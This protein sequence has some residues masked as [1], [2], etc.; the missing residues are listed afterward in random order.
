[1]TLN[2]YLQA[3]GYTYVETDGE[4]RWW[5]EGSEGENAPA[6][7]ERLDWVREQYEA[8]QRVTSAGLPVYGTAGFIPGGVA[9][10]FADYSA[11]ALQAGKTID[12]IDYARAHDA[13]DAWAPAAQEIAA[14]TGVSTIYDDELG[15]LAPV[16]FQSEV[17]QTLNPDAN[18]FFGGGPGTYILQIGAMALG[19]HLATA[20]GAATPAPMPWEPLGAVMTGAPEAVSASAWN[21]FDADDAFHSF[22]GPPLQ[23][24]YTAQTSPYVPTDAPAVFDLPAPAEAATVTSNS[25]SVNVFDADDAFHSLGGAPLPPLYASQI[26]AA[27]APVAAAV[28]A[29]VTNAAV[30]AA[31]DTLAKATAA[32]SALA[33][34]VMGGGGGAVAP[35]VFDAD[36]AF[37]GEG[38]KTAAATGAY[39]PPGTDAPAAPAAGFNW[40][41]VGGVVMAAAVASAVFLKRKGKR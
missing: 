26:A 15:V 3:A 34:A 20:A 4:G 11:P 36:E 38:M 29:G 41:A 27:A 7:A 13:Q 31:V 18:K 32:A 21:V 2:E 33:A 8:Q 23:P 24:V 19:A 9:N 25:G 14:R 5:G 28:N 22:G 30:G 35:N 40:L 12:G 17:A 10:V 39:N 37:L 1:V 16:R 6:T